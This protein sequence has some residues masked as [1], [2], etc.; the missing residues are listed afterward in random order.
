MDGSQ[1][2]VVEETEKISREGEIV[3]I[4]KAVRTIL[5]K[6]LCP[7]YIRDAESIRPASLWEE[8]DFRVGV[9]LYDIQDYS[10]MMTH[11]VRVD[12]KQSRL[13]PKALELS[14]M[15][16]CNEEK[17]FGGNDREKS[18]AVL[19]EI[20]R[21]VYDNPR[22][23]TEDGKEVQLSF[24]KEDMDFKI[25]LWGSFNKPLQPAV[26]VRAVPVLIES[27]RLHG[28]VPVKE[29]TYRVNRKAQREEPQ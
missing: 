12:E 24:A 28:N 11:A 18:A 2:R 20:I 7:V 29:R 27:D 6:A 10:L 5:E 15:I 22:F 23:V 1:N 8:A 21:A 14:Y 13:A 25:K 17:R 26:Y 3:C 16:F 19:N 9:Y 4:G